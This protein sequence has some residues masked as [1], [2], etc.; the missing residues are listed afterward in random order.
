M[1]SCKFWKDQADGFH[2]FCQHPEVRPGEPC[3][4]NT[5]DECLIRMPITTS[6]QIS[7]DTLEALREYGYPAERA[8]IRLLEIAETKA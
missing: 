1:P 3:I 6:M 8:V 7:R 2:G 4:L 5:E